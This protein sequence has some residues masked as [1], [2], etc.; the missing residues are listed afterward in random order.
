MGAALAKAVDASRVRHI[1]NHDIMGCTAEGVTGNHLYSGRVL[2]ASE[3]GD[4]V[5]LHPELASQWDAITAHY[6]RIGLSHATD[7]IWDVSRARLAEHPERGVSV[8][9]FGPDEHSVRPDER[10]LRSVA[11]INSK[12]TFM[13]LAV[14]LG[15]PVPLTIP[16]A[17]VEDITATDI[18][19]APSPCYIKAAVSV[20]GVGIHRCADAAE[21]RSAIGGFDPGTP[22]QIQQEVVTN[23]FLNLQYRCDADGVHRHAAT[24]Q[25]LDGFVHQ[26]NR[27]PARHAPWDTV[28][29]MARWLH[30]E[31]MRGVFAFDVA[32][33]GDDAA[34]EFLAIECNPRFNGASYPTAI[35][36]RLGVDRWLAKAYH[37]RH[38]SLDAVD[39][40]GIEYDST[41][42]TGIVLVNWGPILVGKLLVLLA[43][44]EAT[45]AD[46]EQ[47]LLAR[48]Q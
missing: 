24:E 47:E 23:T 37:T 35:A 15:V 27:H 32:V 39:L 28:E 1:F 43:G 11:A 46:L 38:R 17:R 2:G 42:G 31:G 21:L 25:V 44:D 4:V 18:A 29:P 3:P 9:F 36:H 14:R 48:L 45:Q 8:F 13:E 6:R 34:P 33:V 20:S 40:G 5:Q 22:V 16:F 10:W 19:D 30:D 26:G 41:T 7:V 12:N